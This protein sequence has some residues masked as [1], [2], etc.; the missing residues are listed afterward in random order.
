[1]NDPLH[2]WFQVG[3]FSEDGLIRV[4]W[5]PRW[6]LAAILKNANSRIPEMH[7]PIPFMHLHRPYFALGRYKWLLMHMIGDGT[8]ILRGRITS[9]HKQKEQK[10]IFGE[11]K[12]IMCKDCT[13][14]RPQSK[15]FLALPYKPLTHSVTTLAI[16]FLHYNL[17]NLCKCEMSSNS[18]IYRIGYIAVVT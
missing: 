3:V 14:D 13:L 10:G 6:R 2:V 11:I 12:K 17:P 16:A 8:L 15:V 7:Y 1:M 9:W 4:C 5:N 18:N